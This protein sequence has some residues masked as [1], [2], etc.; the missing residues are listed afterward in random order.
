MHLLV[1]HK[2]EYLTL[3]NKNVPTPVFGQIWD[4]LGALYN[5]T[6][7]QILVV[8]SYYYY[9]KLAPKIFTFTHIE[10]IVNP[11]SPNVG[12]QLDIP[13]QICLIKRIK[14]ELTIPLRKV[15]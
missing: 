5:F 7:N 15:N 6:P 10:P 13:L 8:F 2:L 12:V 9:V 11:E 3:E 4:P 14:R 1:F